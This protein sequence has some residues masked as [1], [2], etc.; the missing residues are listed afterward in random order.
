MKLAIAAF[1]ALSLSACSC[2]VERRAVEEVERT[3]TLISTQLLEYVSADPLIAGPGATEEA[4][5]K[6][7]DDWKGIVESDRR[8]IDRL[9]K[10]LE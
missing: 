9:K 7:R 4:K 8:N 6:A 10:A 2:A 3:H 1:L 5:K